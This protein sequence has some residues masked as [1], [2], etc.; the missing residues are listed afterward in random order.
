MVLDEIGVPIMENG[1]AAPDL[2]AS[3]GRAPPGQVPPRA[4]HAPPCVLQPDFR[5]VSGVSNEIFRQIEMVENDHDATTAAALEAVERRGEMIVRILE[6]RQVGRNNIEA[7]KKFFSLQDSRHA[8]QLVEI[9]KRPGQ[10]LGL[11]IREGD[12]GGRTDGVFISR[13]ALESAVYNSG[14]LKT[15]G[16]YIREGDGGGRTDGVFIS[17][18]ALESAVYNSGCLK[19][20][21]QLVEIVKRPGQTL[22]LYIHEGDGGGRTDGVFI[23]RI[24]LE[25]AVYNSGCLKTLGLYIREGDGGGRTDGVFISR[26]ALE[27][28]VYNSGCLKVGDEILAVNLVDVRRMSLDDVVIIM[29]IPRRLLLCTRQ[30]KGKS[31]PGSPSLPRSEHKPPPVVVLKRD[32]RDDRDDERERDRVDGMYSQH[33]TLRSTGPGSNIRPVGDGREE[34][35]R[36]QLGALSPDSNALDL[37]YNSRPPSDHSTWSYRPPPPVITEQPKSSSTQH[38][39]P[40]ERSYPNT[41]ESLAEKVHSFY[42]NEPGQRYDRFSGRVPRS[43]SEQQLPRAETHSDFGRHS[44]LRSSLKASAATNA[45]LSRY[46]HNQRYGTVGMGGQGITSGLTGSG[47]TGSGLPSG[48]ST[49]GLSGLTGSSLVGSGLTSS[50][51]VGSGLTGAGL[52]STLGQ[53]GTSGLGLPSYS[54]KFGTARRNR[55]LDYSSDTEATAPTRTPY[56]SGLSG[57]RSSTLGRDI[58]SKFNS[59]PRDVRNTGQRLGLSNRRAGSVLQDEPEPLSSRLDLRSSRGRLTSSPS[60][61]TSDE[62]RAWLSRAPSTSA[63]YETLRPRLPTHY[64]AENIHDALKNMENSS[65]FGSTLGLAGR[66]VERPRHLPARSLSSQQL[67][68]SSSPSARRV[69]QLLELGSRFNC[70]NPSPVPTPGS[71]HQRHLDINPNEFLKYKVEK[72]STSGLSSSMTGLSRLAGGG[73]SGML[74]VHLL[75]GRGLRPSPSGASPGSPPSGP[76]APAQPPVAPRDLY[77]VLECDRVHKART[78]VRTGE[79][80]FD[81]DESFELELVD[82][83]QLDVLVYS[84]DPQHRHKLCYRAAVTLPE[85]LARAADHQLALKLVDRRQLG[86]LVYSWDPQHRHKLCY[87]AAVTLPELLAR[88]A[89]H[90]LALKMEPRGTLYMRVRHTEPHELFRRRPAPPRLSPPPL[91]G[92][93]LDAVVSREVRPPHAPPVPLIVRR[94][95]EEI[96][97]RGLDIIGLYR[98]CGSASKKRILRE[99]FERNA[100]GVELAPDSVPDINVITG[101]LK[102]YLRELPQPLFSRC[103]YQMT[104][105]ALGVCLP[106]D[107]EGNARL[108]ASI[109]ECLPRAARATL[110][111]LLDHLALVVAAQDR[112]KMSPQHLAVAMAPPLMLHSQPPTEMD[113]QRPINVLQCLLQIWPAPKRSVRRGDPAPGPRGGRASASPAASA[114]REP[115]RVPPSASPYRPPAAASAAS[116]Q[117]PPSA[118]LAPDRSP[119][120]H[121]LSSVRGGQYRPQSPRGAGAGAGP[122]GARGGRASPPASSSS[123]GSHSPAD[124]IKHGGSV[125]S[126]LRQ[127]EQPSPRASPRASPRDSPRTAIPGTSAGLAVTLNTPRYSSTNPFLQQY[128]PEEEAQAWRAADIFSPPATRT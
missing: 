105:D 67:G 101:L 84:W 15:L 57:Y 16:L 24:A 75:A 108:M 41:L 39:V 7:A 11:Y 106:D 72:P 63:L 9:V 86:V 81:W 80:Q 19:V 28:A 123:S 127:P 21:E 85:L 69:R 128:D 49:T 6:I 14:C 4:N 20:R 93:E 36:M 82:N 87:R 1:R 116:P 91:F 10:T 12:G 90:Q 120:A 61:F 3:P 99:A 103:L 37:Y 13:I 126:I 118:R 50:G 74:W 54:S 100:R 66:R 26:I 115:G 32:C 71:R 58:G 83:R 117:P 94:C 109:V 44:L 56:Y 51:L 29:S 17:R 18:I 96:E 110:V 45:S 92:A 111:F 42:P 34:R 79:L 60:V 40:Y 47:L 97:R 70:P 104:L 31:G 55:S 27:S 89:D 95:V 25:S 119:P 46:A 5:K 2:T 121:V 30:R 112:N 38:F 33:G 65:R 8:V 113:Y 48:L 23:S 124:T 62:Y 88:A 43:G 98:L 76:L 77:C 114:T 102:D 59:L 73:M 68:P 53:Y 35:S 52:S 107:R 78:V 125:S 22:G 122:A 64:S